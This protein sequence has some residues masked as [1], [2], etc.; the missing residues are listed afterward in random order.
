MDN[1]KVIYRILH[2]LEQAMN[3]NEPDLER[4]S[5]S[6]LKITEQR[7]AAIMKMLADE[8]YIEGVAVKQSLDGDMVISIAH[9]RI[10]LRGLEYLQSNVLMQKAAM[11]AKG[12]M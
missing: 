11:L 1:F 10:T 5:A 3:W 4:I 7:W 9:P 12:I 6:V 8:R 2:Y